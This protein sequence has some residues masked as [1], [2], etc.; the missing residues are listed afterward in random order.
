MP[1]DMPTTKRF[2]NVRFGLETNTQTFT[3]PFTKTVQRLGLGGDRWIATY[4]L[5]MMN[6]AQAAP[7]KAFFDLLEGS[8]NMF[9]G[10]DPDCTEPLG[11]GTGTP[12]VNGA[13][14]TGSALSIDGCTPSVMFLKTGDYFAVNGELKRLTADAPADGSGH[15]VLNFKPALRAAPADNA[16]ITVHKP[17][18]T[19]ILTDDNQAI[20]ESDAMGI[21]QAKT[22]SAYEAFF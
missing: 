5:P 22:F 12:L 16:P 21:Y 7:W 11:S 15:A 1:I 14:Q 20:F 9:N 2:T 4:S 3:S 19:M 8:V 10:F 6:R 18:C 17:T 13:D